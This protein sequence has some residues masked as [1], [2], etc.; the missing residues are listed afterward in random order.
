M[1]YDD[2][3]RP[4]VGPSPAFNFPKALIRIPP[5]EL[6][7]VGVCQ[8]EAEIWMPIRYNTGRSY[9]CSLTSEADLLALLVAWREDPEEAVEHYFKYKI[10]DWG[11]VGEI[12]AHAPLSVD[13]LGL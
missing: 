1:R 2:P 3:E 4:N 12:G 6:T 8:W 9:V 7:P 13:D 10:E 11:T 5:I